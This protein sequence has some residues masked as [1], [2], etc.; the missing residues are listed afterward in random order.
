MGEIFIN[1]QC[2]HGNTWVWYTL[3]AKIL[4]KIILIFGKGRNIINIK[5]IQEEFEDTKE[6]IRIRI[7][8]KNRHHNDKKKKYKRTN[9]DL[10]YKT[11]DRVTRTPLK[12]GVNTGAPEG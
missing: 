9:N 11:K 5:I 12:T 4:D 10:Q 1:I 2:F 3:K 6:V 7:S 8:K